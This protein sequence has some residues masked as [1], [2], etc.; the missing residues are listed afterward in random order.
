MLTSI[1]YNKFK[2][3]KVIC[4]NCGCET[5]VRDAEYRRQLKKGRNY[6]A[7]SMSCAMS[8]VNKNRVHKPHSKYDFDA[9]KVSEEVKSYLLGFLCG[10]GTVSYKQLKDE[11]R[12]KAVVAYSTD[13]EILEKIKEA[14]KY[15]GK[16][17]LSKKE[18]ENNLAC[19]S[20]I[21][22]SSTAQK[23]IDWGLASE[24]EAHELTKLDIKDMRAFLRGFIDSDGTISLHS[25]KTNVDFLGREKLINQLNEVLKEFGFRIRKL[26]LYGYTTQLWNLA[27]Y[28]RKLCVNFIKWLYEGAS[29]Y[30]ERKHKVATEIIKLYG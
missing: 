14:L 24:K 22:Y 20:L 12:V 2:I 10:D 27:I 21:F 19:Y 8:Y 16:I 18:G 3:M 23:I 29:I 30:M 4:C 5:E 15:N 28:D 6:F 25:G 7:C 17:Y 13:L 26:P 9:S 11:Y 1:Y